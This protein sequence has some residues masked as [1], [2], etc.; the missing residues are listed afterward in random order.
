MVRFKKKVTRALTT[1]Y[2]YFFMQTSKTTDWQISIS[3]DKNYL[4]YVKRP[5]VAKKK[6][7]KSKYFIFCWNTK[8]A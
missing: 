1:K 6:I 2:Q 5:D 7:S 4:F 8:K 3:S